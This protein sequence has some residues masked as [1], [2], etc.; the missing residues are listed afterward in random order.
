MEV[1][2]LSESNDALILLDMSCYYF[3]MPYRTSDFCWP[4]LEYGDNHDNLPKS[5]K[6]LLAFGLKNI[7][8]LIS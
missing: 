2:L 5:K 1:V 4:M 3:L 6:N 8:F 7:A